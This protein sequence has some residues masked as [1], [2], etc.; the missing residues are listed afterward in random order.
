MVFLAVGCDEKRPVFVNIGQEM[1]L[2]HPTMSGPAAKHHIR[3]TVGQGVC[4]LDFDTDGD[5]DLFMPNGAA[6]VRQSYDASPGDLVKWL[7]Y[8]NDRGRFIESAD[9][10]GLTGDTWGVGCAAGDVDNDG[11]DD[12]FVTTAV[13]GNRLY[14]NSGEGHFVD[15]TDRAGVAAARFSTGAAFGDLDADGDLDLVVVTYL[16]ETWPAPTGCR[17]KG[18]DVPCGPQSYAPLDALLYMNDGQGRFEPSRAL[19]GR[20]GYGLGVVLFDA[21]G[22]GDLDIFVANDSSPNHLFINMGGGRFVETGLMRGV[23]LSIV[24]TSQAGM[25]VDAGDL[26]G[27]GLSDLVITN[28]SDDVNNLFRNDGDGFFSEWSYKSGLAVASF[29]MLGWSVLLEDFDL[30]GDLDVFV[31]NGHLYPEAGEVDSDTAYLQRMQLLLNDGTAQLTEVR[32][33]PG[34]VLDTPIAGRGGAAADI[35]GDGDVDVVVTRDGAPPLVLRNDLAPADAH[36]L[37]VQLRGRTSNREG[38]GATVTVESGARRQVREM[39]RSRGYLSAGPAELVIGLGT[40]NYV[41]RLT[42]GWPAG[43]R[44]VLQEIAADQLLVVEEPRH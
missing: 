34:S 19:A 6:R 33:A 8:V 14:R 13:G 20:A 1:G 30:D 27:D 29:P 36:W 22:D 18:V 5:L 9:R 26:D 16:V 43:R 25:G 15:W 39:R 35:D 32:D 12:L 4:L 11:L 7:F 10:V 17:W 24:G 37:R 28:F 40:A 44:Q 31:V 2:T 3:E 23:A 38:V 42:V 41:D 21:D